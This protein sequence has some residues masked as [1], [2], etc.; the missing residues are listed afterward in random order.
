MKPEIT[1]RMGRS[2]RDMETAITLI[3]DRLASDR[4]PSPALLNG[5]RREIDRVGAGLA[6]V[7]RVIEAE[8]AT[9]N[10]AALDV[11][12]RERAFFEP[13]ARML[14]TSPLGWDE[15][16]E[17]L[18]EAHGVVDDVGRPLTRTRLVRL[19]IANGSRYA[20]G[21]FVDDE[22]DEGRAFDLL[23]L[24]REVGRAGGLAPLVRACY[25]GAPRYR[26]IWRFALPEDQLTANG[27]VDD[28]AD[29]DDEA[30]IV[31]EKG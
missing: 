4:V 13:L 18:A 15:I 2:L 27:V 8:A 23:N 5:I 28:D 10:A 11:T 12:D 1:K 6:T 19:A 20:I 26:M 7:R 25:D 21:R 24:P 9:V 14:R 29:L 17:A 30:A 3:V 22:T 16:G 31:D